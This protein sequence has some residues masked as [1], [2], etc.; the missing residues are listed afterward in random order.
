MPQER[1]RDGLFPLHVSAQGRQEREV[2]S[3]EDQGGGT[4]TPTTQVHYTVKNKTVQFS[5]DG[6]TMLKNTSCH[7][8]LNNF[9]IF[10]FLNLIPPTEMLRAV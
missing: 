9:Q 2:R 7:L 3:W 8:E 5:K 4:E 1:G 6:A 10:F